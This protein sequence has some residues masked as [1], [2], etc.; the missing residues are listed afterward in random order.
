MVSLQLF[1]FGHRCLWNL[2]PTTSM[3]FKSSAFWNA[4]RLKICFKNLPLTLCCHHKISL[5]HMLEILFLK[6]RLNGFWVMNLNFKTHSYT[7]IWTETTLFKVYFRL[8]FIRY[9]KISLYAWV[10]E[11]S[12][13]RELRGIV[14]DNT[15]WQACRLTTSYKL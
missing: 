5:K 3:Y 2:T 10:K 12:V 8:M 15:K 14:F 7:K 6:C 1:S 4:W 13:S 9:C 11:Q